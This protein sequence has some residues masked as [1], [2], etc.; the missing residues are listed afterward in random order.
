MSIINGIILAV[1]M[2]IIVLAIGYVRKIR[3]NRLKK[4]QSNQPKK[5][6]DGEIV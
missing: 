1:G 5:E 3:P 2:F 6:N 4:R